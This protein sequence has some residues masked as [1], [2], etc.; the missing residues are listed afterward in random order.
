MKKKKFKVSAHEQKLFFVVTV[1]ETNR[2]QQFSFIIWAM[3]KYIY[4]QALNLNGL[5]Y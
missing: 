1:K 5:F 3:E 4:M 2:F